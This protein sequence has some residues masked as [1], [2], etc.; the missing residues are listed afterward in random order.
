MIPSTLAVIDDVPE[1]SEALQIF[2]TDDKQTLASNIGA[3][4]QDSSLTHV[5]SDHTTVSSDVIPAITH[6]FT[7]V[8]PPEVTQCKE[9]LLSNT[10]SFKS[11][12]ASSKTADSELPYLSR[13]RRPRDSLL[14]TTPSFLALKRSSLIKK[15]SSDSIRVPKVPQSIETRMQIIPTVQCDDGFFDDNKMEADENLRN[16]IIGERIAISCT[17]SLTSLIDSLEQAPFAQAYQAHRDDTTQASEAAAQV[18]LRGE[19]IQA[20]EQ[21]VLQRDYDTRPRSTSPTKMALPHDMV[22]M[23][24]ELDQLAAEIRGLPIPSGPATPRLDA[25]DTAPPTER[26]PPQHSRSDAGNET[27]TSVSGEKAFLPV[28]DDNRSCQP[29]K[30]K[31]NSGQGSQLPKSSRLGRPRRYTEGIPGPPLA[32]QHSSSGSPVKATMDSKSLVARR[33]TIGPA[34]AAPPR[35]SLSPDKKQLTFKI[36]LAPVH[37]PR[38]RT[39]TSGQDRSPLVFPAPSQDTV[40]FGVGMNSTVARPSGAQTQSTNVGSPSRPSRSVMDSPTKNVG[41]ATAVSEFPTTQRARSRSFSHLTHKLSSIAKPKRPPSDPPLEPTFVPPMPS[42]ISSV[43]VPQTEIEKPVPTLHHRKSLFHPRRSLAPPAVDMM[44]PV[45]PV[46]PT[47]VIGGSRIARST[48]YSE[49]MTRTVK[50][51]H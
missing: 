16:E 39:H 30:P 48:R 8:I 49:G 26:G 45:S 15:T 4:N 9:T 35:R 31:C 51:L 32:S 22:M 50:P 47:Q 24:D 11:L 5:D 43:S 12:K 13:P 10:P 38:Y 1:T 40:K 7:F 33:S 37:T 23:L 27:N 46:K 20:T 29:E 28:H 41:T 19:R 25:H 34:T 18:V 21:N 44:G 3:D 42:P 17:R 2:V 36:N 6:T 14:L